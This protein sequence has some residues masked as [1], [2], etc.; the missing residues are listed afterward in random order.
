MRKQLEKGRDVILEIEIQ[1]ALKVK[2][3]FPTAL[4]LFVMPPSVSELKKRLE[5]RGTES[6]EV[7]KRRLSRAGEEADGIENYD[8]IVINDKL[9]ECVRNMHSLIQAAH[10]MPERNVE[11]ID[12]IRKELKNVC[13]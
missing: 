13:V 12:N 11:L 10:E 7:I 5:G 6:P 9:E 4:L 1:G 8:F 3:Q 2:E